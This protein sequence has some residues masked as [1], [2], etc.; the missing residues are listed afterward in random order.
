MFQNSHSYINEA[1]CFPEVS[2]EAFFGAGFVVL[3]VDL[4][5]ST[6]LWFCLAEPLGSNSVVKLTHFSE[7]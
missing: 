4:D 5:V 6:L 1:K 2:G 7:T 3:Q